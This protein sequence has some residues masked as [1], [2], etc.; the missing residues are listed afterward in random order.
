MSLMFGFFSILVK[1]EE[2]LNPKVKFGKAVVLFRLTSW[3][4]QFERQQ[5]L[6]FSKV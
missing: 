5:L 1:K 2:L 6:V 4:I 3:H